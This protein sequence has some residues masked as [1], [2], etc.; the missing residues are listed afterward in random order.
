LSDDLIFRRNGPFAN[1]LG[2]VRSNSPYYAFRGGYNTSH[3]KELGVIAGFTA[4]IAI[5]FYG[6]EFAYAWVP[7]GDLG[8]SH[9]FS[10]LLRF[11][12]EPRRNRAYPNLA[13][14]RLRQSKRDDDEDEFQQTE[15]SAPGYHDY[16]NIDDLLSDNERQLLRKQRAESKADE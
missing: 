5:H 2:L 16:G 15:T 10:L 1:A 12:T 9:Y 14:E 8:N 3:T 7:F 4:G 6:Q 13:H 11:S